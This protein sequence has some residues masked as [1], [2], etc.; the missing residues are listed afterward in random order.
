M[1]KTRFGLVL[2][3]IACVAAQGFVHW[4]AMRSVKAKTALLQRLHER[5]GALDS[6]SLAL[7]KYR[8]LSTSFRRMSGVE[9]EQT[10]EQ[11]LEFLIASAKLEAQL[12]SKDAYT[13]QEIREQHDAIGR[14]LAQMR[15]A[16]ERR[17]AEAGASAA[18]DGKRSLG[19]IL[20]IGAGV[21]A[22]VFVL[23]LWH[24]LRHV[25]PLRLLQASREACPN[26]EA[27][28]LASVRRGLALL[29]ASL[30]ETAQLNRS[31]SGSKLEESVIDL[32]EL[33][34][35]VSRVM[36]G[37]SGRIVATRVPALPVWV[38]CDARRLERVLL[39]SVA[40]VLST[41]PESRPL[42][43]EVLENL[44]PGVEIRIREFD[45]RNPQRD[46]PSGGPRSSLA[47]TGWPS[48]A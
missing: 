5:E 7:E 47:A 17:I 38:Q 43:I 29:S 2:G 15:A 11:L 12:Y 27:D 21:A 40:R 13:K 39:Q 46:L 4:Q 9:V 48:R 20:G 37:A 19:V 18:D 6:M 44:G 3:V 31:A 10:K 42:R 41:L 16:T 30:K 34:G 36:S 32:S 25:R 22:L 1:T 28:A 23:M 24:W 35:D 45:P 26:Q 14:A 33:V 8:R